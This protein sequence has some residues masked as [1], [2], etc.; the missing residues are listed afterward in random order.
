MVAIKCGKMVD[1]DM[2]VIE[3]AVVLVENGKI[4]AAGAGVEIPAGAE[5]VDASG[6]WVTPGLIEAHAH[7]ASEMQDINEMSNPITPDLRAFD[8]VYPFSEDIKAIREAGFTSMVLL[9]GSA[10]LIGGSGVVLKNKPAKTVYEMAVYGR[11]PLKMALGENPRR[12]YTGKFTG[13]RMANA[14]L[15]R[16]T[17]TR[18][19]DYMRQKEAGK[20]EKTE[21]EMEALIPVLKGEKRVHM[22]SHKADDLVTAVRLL[23]EFGLDFTLDH[24]T[25]GELIADWLAEN[26]IL[27]VVGPIRIQPLKREMEGVHPSLPGVL[28]KAGV[29]FALTSDDNYGIQFLPMTVGHCVAHGLSW[30]A[31]MRGITLTAAKALQIEDRVGSLEPGKD[32]DIAFFSGDPLLNTTRCVG[33]MIDG[34][35]CSRSF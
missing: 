19:Q 24:V 28:E 29:E 4:A 11:E 14:A 13:T 25:Q 1:R 8:A 30:E 35:F 9:P 5:V 31:G 21:L 16:R 32:A 6:L 23:R 18:A 33:T 26:K 34:G 17:F 12:C 7:G 15:V 22:H 10:N 2:R 20:L 3:N 27:C